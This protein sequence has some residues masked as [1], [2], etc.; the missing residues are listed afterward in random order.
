MTRIRLNVRVLH[1]A[2]SLK[3][4]LA[5]LT[6]VLAVNS[7]PVWAQQRAPLITDRP[8]Q[9]ESSSV[10]PRGSVQAELGW[11][12][13]R[14]EE[15]AVT[16]TT[17]SLPEVLVR[18]GL[19]GEVEARLGFSGWQSV[20]PGGGLPSVS[21][22]GDITVGLKY[23]IYSHAAGNVRASIIAF[24]SLP[25][26]DSDFGSDRVDPEIRLTVDGEVSERVSLGAN[27]GVA[28]TTETVAGNSNSR[29]DAIYTVVTGVSVSERVGAFFEFF[30]ALA[31]EGG[32]DIHSFDTG[33]T[34]ALSPTM[35][36]DLSV[37]FGLNA[38]ADDYFIGAGFSI[39]RPR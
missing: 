11:T 9:T 4:V 39:R 7:A 30:G 31:G 32:S 27:L 29:A 34:F 28:V 25:T 13:S 24:T 8:D 36:L 15:L 37:G 16:T 38:A 33:L 22:I 20:E 1:R 14:E 19:N 2:G 17:L 12:F 3:S 6:V 35:Q 21:G 10:V 23:A 26:G 18:I 5:T